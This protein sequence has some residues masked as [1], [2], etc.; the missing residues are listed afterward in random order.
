MSEINSPTE[1]TVSPFT[2]TPETG[3][4]L[5]S[6]LAVYNFSLWGHGTPSRD[7]ESFFTN[8]VRTASDIGIDQV[9]LPLNP[10]PLDASATE[11]I[12]DMELMN[13]WPHN[14]GAE[15]KPGVVLF[16]IPN[17]SIE[18]NVHATRLMAG[19][20]DDE[21]KRV[22]PHLVI[23]YYEPETQEVTPNPDFE[24]TDTSYASEIEAIKLRTLPVE[25]ML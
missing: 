11:T 20:V 12:A 9:A 18:D 3:K 5:A 1:T 16:A 14:R 23:G 4:D 24:L 2:L 19:V 6:R 17:P 21:L 25:S 22:P 10:S 7:I 13:Q 15:R 8:G